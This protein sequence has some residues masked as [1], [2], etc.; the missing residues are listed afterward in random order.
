MQLLTNANIL[1]VIICSLDIASMVFH[2][3][4][5]LPSIRQREDEGDNSMVDIARGRFLNNGVFLLL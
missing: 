1:T 5:N 2:K 4:F 3:L